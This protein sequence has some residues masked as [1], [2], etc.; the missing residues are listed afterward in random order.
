[1]YGHSVTIFTNHAAVSAVLKSPT[2]SGKHAQWWTKVF[3]SEI[4]DVEIIYRPGKEN[5]NADA[6]SRQLHAQASLEGIAE[7]EV[8]M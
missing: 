6:L 3:G 5:C 2:P 4:K 7:G 8:Q 1:M